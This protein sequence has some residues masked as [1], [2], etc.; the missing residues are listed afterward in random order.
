MMNN[1]PSNLVVSILFCLV[2]YFFKILITIKVENRAV[3]IALYLVVLTMGLA[4]L[5]LVVV[6]WHTPYENAAFHWYG[7]P[8][9]FLAIPTTTF[10]YDLLR[11][12]ERTVRFLILRSV[13][14]IF[15]IFPI[16]CLAVLIF[17]FV[18]LL[19]WVTI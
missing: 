8:I 11:R 3:A 14:E 12:K 2:L 10:I 16:W 1:Y 15:V 18:I 7:V 19:G 13:L 9:L 17:V 4:F 6:E 5:Y